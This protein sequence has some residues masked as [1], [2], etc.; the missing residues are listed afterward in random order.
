MRSLN[1]GCRQYHFPELGRRAMRELLDAMKRLST[2]CDELIPD[3]ISQTPV[4]FATNPLDYARVPAQ[5]YIEKFGHLGAKTVMLGMNPG[6]W[7]MAQTGIPFGATGIVR[8]LLAINEEVFQPVGAHPK[9]PVEGIFLSRQEVSGTRLWGLLAEHYGSVEEIHKHVYLVNHCP[10]LLI[11][12]DG[13]NLTPDKLSGQAAREL[14]AVCDQHLI[15]VVNALEATR[16]I[17]VGKYA[18]K[19]AHKATSDLEITSVW[20]PS[21]A[22]PLAN[23]NNGADWKANVLS[24]LL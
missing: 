6:P 4:A 17:G 22:S 15:D 13:K 20:H 14:L 19:R 12:E 1:L 24:T 9:R 10:L 21:P 23:R 8:D 7:G 11:S 2:R 18:E 16:I 5:T 3:L